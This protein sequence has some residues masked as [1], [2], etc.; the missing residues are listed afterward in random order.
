MTIARF[1]IYAFLDRTKPTKGTVEIDRE[2]KTFTV[3]PHRAHQTYSMPLD[4]VASMVVRA[5]VAA[6]VRDKKIAKKA[7]RRARE[8]E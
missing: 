1:P 2:Q 7:A 3:R 4:I 8:R 5:S 6:E